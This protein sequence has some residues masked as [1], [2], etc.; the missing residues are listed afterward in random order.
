MKKIL[1]GLISFFICGAFFAGTVHS[2]PEQI[3]AVAAEALV[4]QYCSL[5][6]SGDTQ[7]I[8]DILAGPMLKKRQHL[9]SSN[10]DYGVM[11]AQ[12]YNDARFEIET[13]RPVNFNRVSVDTSIRFEDGSSQ[14]LRFIVEKIS[15]SLKIVDEVSSF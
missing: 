12:R 5:L 7:A 6:K 9:L 13:A 11:L 15:K 8:H 2:A 14:K 4:T 10:H 3:D 1:C